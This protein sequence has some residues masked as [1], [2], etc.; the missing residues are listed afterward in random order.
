MTLHV[1]IVRLHVNHLIDI[2]S[3]IYHMRN[4]VVI[5]SLGLR[6]EATRHVRFQ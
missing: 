4:M 1:F 3:F 5:Q 2:Q 6:N